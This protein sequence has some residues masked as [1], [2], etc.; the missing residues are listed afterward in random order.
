M[1]GGGVALFSLGVLVDALGRRDVGS[2]V[3]EGAFPVPVTHVRV[4]VR[5]KIKSDTVWLIRTI[6]LALQGS[7]VGSWDLNSSIG[8]GVGGQI[9][10]GCA[11]S[12]NVSLIA[13][14]TIL[15]QLI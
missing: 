12:F 9:V 7:I 15:L 3:A 4:C 13:V 10:G 11:A 14:K 6:S 8:D 5:I 1:S 2:P